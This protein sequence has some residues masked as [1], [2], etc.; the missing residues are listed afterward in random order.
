MRC[1]KILFIGLLVTLVWQT[2]ASPWVEPDNPMLRVNLQ[3][4]ADAGYIKAPLTTFPLQ[5]A[6]ISDDLQRIDPTT[7]PAY[8]KLSYRYVKHYYNDARLGRGNSHL[9]MMSATQ[10]SYNLGYGSFAR[11]NWGVYS[12]YESTDANYSYRLN[13]NYAKQADGSK[14][15][16][17]QGSYLAMAQGQYT[18]AAGELDRWWGPGW[19]SSLTWSQNSYP[20][21]AISVSRFGLN[22]LVLGDWSIIS[23]VGKLDSV[24]PNNYLWGTRAMTHP[25]QWLEL[26]GSFQSYWGASDKQPY[27]EFPDVVVDNEDSAKRQ[28]SLDMHIQLPTVAEVSQGIYGQVVSGQ[29]QTELSSYLYGWESSWFVLGQQAHLIFERQELRDSYQLSNDY[30]PNLMVDGG[31][32]INDQRFESLWSAGGY[33]LFSNNHQLQL[34]VHRIN[35]QTDS[36]YYQTSLEYQLPLWKGQ[37]HLGGDYRSQ[38]MNG[39]RLGMWIGWDF[40]FSD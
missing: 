34:F 4:L 25:V 21:P 40:R 31:L 20:I 10:T 14:D 1:F 6:L 22:N 7:L 32:A 11:D 16:N 27:Q 23:L 2:Q 30:D 35:P 33:L 28:T 5:W 3:Q 24:S 38:R 39:D 15:F 37:L 9:R 13:A 19:Q 18:I 26:G 12:S 17:Y 29:S 36:T 8:L